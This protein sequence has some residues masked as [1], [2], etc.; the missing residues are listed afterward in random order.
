[1]HRT[2][3][4]RPNATIR[5][6]AVRRPHETVHRTVRTHRVAPHRTVVTRKTTVH[7]SGPAHGRV[8]LTSRRPAHFHRVFR[9][10]HRY[11]VG[12]WHAP[13]G[14]AYRRFSIGERIPAVLLA[15]EF[16]LTGYD[17]YGLE[18]PP[19]GYIW[20]RDGNDAVLVDQETGEV[21]EVVYD[22]FY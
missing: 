10:P 3:V 5:R 4:H 18:V 1:V 11:R 13:R 22:V 15:A 9:A 2:A 16:F 17:A 8:T 12:V 7:R 20:V 19:D 6:T 14:F 21:V